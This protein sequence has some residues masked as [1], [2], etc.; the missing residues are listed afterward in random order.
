[1]MPDAIPSELRAIPQWVSWRAESNGKGELTKIPFV[2]GSNRRASTTNPAT[3]ST[4]DDARSRMNG[5]AGLGFVFTLEAGMIDI[6]LDKVR[7]PA[8]GEIATW[9][10]RI[11][12]R[13]STYAEISPS[14]T[15][16]HL[17]GEGPPLPA[18]ARKRGSLELYDEKRYFTIT[19][20]H[21]EGAPATIARVNI[22]W[23]HRLMAAGLFDFAKHPKLAALMNGDT[24]GY[25]SPS[26]ADLALCSLLARLGLDAAG[27]FEAANISALW[28]SKWE[29]EDYQ[30]RTISAALKNLPA[31]RTPVT[32]PPERDAGT[33]TDWREKLICGETGKPLR[34][35]GNAVTALRSAPE[36]RDLLAFDE[37]S[38][39]IVSRRLTPWETAAGEWSDVDDS[40]LC[41]WLGQYGIHI[42]SKVA[43]EAVEIVARDSR[44]HPLRE[45]LNSC[46]VD[47][48]GQPRIANWLSTY[49]GVESSEYS[50]AIGKAFLI[51][52]VARA[53]RPGCKCDNVLLL[54]GPQGKLKSTAFRALV[55][56]AWFSD[57]ISSF[58]SKDSREELLG[59][60]VCELAELDRVRGSALE[61]TK[62]FLST[63]CDRFRKSY[64][65]RAGI[66]PRSTV[67]CGSTND[68]TYLCDESGARRFWP[69]KIG[70]IKID[71]LHRDRSQLWGEAVHAHRAGDP[72]W[73]AP[74][75]EKLASVEQ[76]QRY[77][78][79][80]RDNLIARWIVDP[81]PNPNVSYLDWFGSK[82]G[83]I[84][85]TDVLLHGL[86]IPKAH[87]K[88]GSAESREVARCLRHLGYESKQE[89]G[90]EYRDQRYFVKKEGTE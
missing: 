41:A 12:E 29:R 90:G 23:L 11:I 87:L 54:E 83:R 4:F 2:S 65:R 44:V 75:L 24:A 28:D 17:I 25:P 79:G 85:I 38:Q 1:M 34:V 60:W 26:E 56:D 55:G 3:W 84:H 14:G 9:A 30:E 73:L 21:L 13:V 68:S 49:L 39:Y 45:F 59:V 27:V 53:Y 15:G 6:D 32:T 36:L 76:K 86:Q 52:C 69:V 82:E 77:E 61:R 7:N 20:Q 67:F 33:E 48:D 10:Q 43:A 22:A 80:S 51:A 19:G 18:G 78:G 64:G 63:S 8:T 58:G 35:I 74:E 47:W 66:Y 50:R 88:H 42:S 72:W 81:Q 31:L 70:I 40:N 71:D 62:S 5:D 57:T 16:I 89:R 46:A 37:F